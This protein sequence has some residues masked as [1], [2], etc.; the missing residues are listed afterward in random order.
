MTASEVVPRSDVVQRLGGNVFTTVGQVPSSYKDVTRIILA[1]TKFSPLFP[2]GKAITETT[3]CV[4]EK[5]TRESGSEKRLIIIIHYRHTRRLRNIS[6][7]FPF[8][9]IST[10][11]FIF[12]HGMPL[13][14]S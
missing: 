9:K 4:G 1:L 10:T 5:S 2:L 6:I 11:T 13:S 7:Y 3:R 14:M 8:D 12:N